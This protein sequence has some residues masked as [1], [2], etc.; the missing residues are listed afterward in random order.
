VEQGA[1]ARERTLPGH[2]LSRSV[3]AI[4]IHDVTKRNIRFRRNLCRDRLSRAAA[5]SW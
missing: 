4:R 5:S 1:D 2:I 3:R